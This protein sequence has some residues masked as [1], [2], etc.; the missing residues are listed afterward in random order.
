MTEHTL[1][2]A[3]PDDAAAF[4]AIYAPS[5]VGSAISF[6]VT[7]PTAAEMSE[8]V[9]A[10]QAYV[11]WLTCEVTGS[12]GGGVASRVGGYAYVSRHRERAAYQWSLDAAVYV[13]ADQQRRGI[14][15]ALYTTL[16]GL[17]RLQGYYA[18]HAGISLPN[19]ASVA[20]HEALGFRPVGVYAAVGYKE[21]AWRDV[22]WWQLEL[23]P[24]SGNPAP[25]LLPE[26]A[27]TQSPAEWAACFEAGQRLLR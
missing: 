25:P 13:S 8:R 1:R 17:A 15:R 10:V 6:E 24:R 5:I 23:Q 16:F 20:L 12:A 22:G 19:P 26:Q 9:T 14:A 18:V 21:G 7:P 3:R 27:R 2:S 4:C 11:P